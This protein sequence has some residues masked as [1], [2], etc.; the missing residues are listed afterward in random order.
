[1]KIWRNFEAEQIYKYYNE[2]NNASKENDKTE[3]KKDED[4]NDEI[5][6]K[7]E[8]NDE[9][10]KKIE[11]DI[12]IITL[13]DDKSESESISN[14]SDSKSCSI[15][16]NS[17]SN[18][19]NY[20]VYEPNEHT[21]ESLVFKSQS[22]NYCISRSDV[23]PSKDLQCYW[24]SP[25]QHNHRCSIFDLSMNELFILSNNESY[26]NDTIMDWMMKY[27]FCSWSASFKEKVF[28]FSSFFWNTIS[29]FQYPMKSKRKNKQLIVEQNLRKMKNHLKGRKY[30]SIFEKDFV[31][32]PIC[33]HSHW[34]LVIVCYPNAMLQKNKEDGKCCSI[35]ILDSLNGKRKTSK[36][37]VIQRWMNFEYHCMEKYEQNME[38]VKNENISI[39]RKVTLKNCPSLCAQVPKQPNFVDCGVFALRNILQFGKQFGFENTSDL[40]MVNQCTEEWYSIEE[41]VEY[42]AEIKL[43]MDE[44]IEDQRETLDKRRKRELKKKNKKRRKKQLLITRNKNKNRDEIIIV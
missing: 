19:V 9:C 13:S 40:K 44:L 35:L 6:I 22:L 31:I 30:H 5:E 18:S 33:T 8:F 27:T 12:E 11:K 38:N 2:R 36:I 15:S 1:M 32:F 21:I 7:E 20:E 25:A 24:Y 23:K 29:K 14:I 17:S 34:E 10:M 4:I 26:L 28:I 43:I 16:L 41:G 3:E 42:R 39:A 37:R